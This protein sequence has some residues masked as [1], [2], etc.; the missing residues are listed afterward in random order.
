MVVRRS[1][2]KKT[3]DEMLAAEAEGDALRRGEKTAALR[4]ELEHN[5]AALA[6]AEARVASTRQQLEA[7][8]SAQRRADESP[9]LHA[10]SAKDLG[11]AEGSGETFRI[12][13]KPFS[14]GVRMHDGGSVVDPTLIQNLELLTR[15]GFLSR[16]VNVRAVI[17]RGV[18]CEDCAGIY[19]NRSEGE[20]HWRRRHNSGAKER[21]AQMRDQERR[22]EEDAARARAE[23][24]REQARAIGWRDSQAEA[25]AQAK[26]TSQNLGDP[27]RRPDL[28]DD[29]LPPDAA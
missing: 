2:V 8:E 1:K 9:R 24:Q 15:Q 21:L 4:A 27:I 19:A 18:R 22:S 3:R 5:E 29:Y 6:E 13:T 23:Y 16:I 25:F 14:D 17:D 7:I 20:L 12:V 26:R 28:D 10:V 11:V